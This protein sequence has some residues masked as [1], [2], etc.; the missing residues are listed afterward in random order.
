LHHRLRFAWET[1]FLSFLDFASKGFFFFDLVICIFKLAFRGQH[2]M[3]PS[4][5][6][7]KNDSL[8]G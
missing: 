5:T 2:R 8:K 7:T 1:F 4:M 3:E 6:T